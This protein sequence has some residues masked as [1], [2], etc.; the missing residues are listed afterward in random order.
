MAKI[1]VDIDALGTG[2]DGLAKG[3]DGARLIVPGALPGERVRVEP[4]K[5]GRCSTAE[6]L[7]PSPDRVAAP[8][9]HFGACGGCSIQHLADG[10]YAVWKTGLARAALARDGLEP[11]IAP[12]R[13]VAPKTRRRA[14]LA[15]VRAASGVALGFHSEN[16][17]SIVDLAACEVLA[18]ALFAALP[19]L[20]AALA[21]I[22]RPAQRVDVHL[23]ATATGIDVLLT[24]TAPDAKARARL[25][26]YARAADIPRVAWRA[27]P[28]NGPEIVALRRVPTL[29]LSGVPVEPPPGAFL[30]ASAEAEAILIE[31][32]AGALGKAK[33]VADLYAG[34]GTFTFPLAARVRAFEGNDAAR[35]ALDAAARK[36]KRAGKVEAETRDL[37]RRPLTPPELE[38]YDAAVFDPPR[39]GAEAQARNL[40]RSRVPIV[41]GVSCN[42]VTFARDA[43]LLVEG[44]YTLTRVAPVDQ[45]PW[46]G[47]LEL[48]GVFAKAKRR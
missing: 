33:R 18:P 48:V 10:A 24:D 41:V 36:A 37:D 14:E 25:A 21:D 16:S 9:R 1:E 6:I 46:T 35:A 29:A 38:A 3:P 12:L 27:G 7:V 20:R 31:E 17:A 28:R 40:A 11:E 15:A 8:C 44:G 5:G 13:R 4:G 34:L 22:L 32:V 23:T 45:F 2:G 47:H 43:K 30:Q 19:A 26:E 39:E 42:P